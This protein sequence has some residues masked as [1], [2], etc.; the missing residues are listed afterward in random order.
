[1]L[2]TGSTLT[3]PCAQQSLPSSTHLG[4]SPLLPLALLAQGPGAGSMDMVNP[5]SPLGLL[6]QGAGQSGGPVSLQPPTSPDTLALQPP[7]PTPCGGRGMRLVSPHLCNPGASR[8]HHA[9]RKLSSI[10]L[11]LAHLH[12]SRP[13]LLSAKHFLSSFPCCASRLCHDM[14][15]GMFMS[16]QFARRNPARNQCYT[17]ASATH[18][19]PSCL[20]RDPRLQSQSWR[21]SSPLTAPPPPVPST[22]AMA[23]DGFR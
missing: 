17:Q 1:M 11:A 10:C 20:P 18:S 16:P 19:A 3:S 12:L 13:I 22:T 8:R 6:S 23:G 5:L 7:S 14:A 9:G 21:G 15:L 4:M 2:L